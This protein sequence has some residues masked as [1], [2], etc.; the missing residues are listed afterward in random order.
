[1]KLQ[2]IIFHTI[3]ISIST[4]SIFGQ[5]VQKKQH[6]TLQSNDVNI[7]DEQNL[8]WSELDAYVGKY[9][10]DTGFFENDLVK[11]ELKKILDD[12]FN[13]Y[14]KFVET[15]GYGIIE[16]VDN[17][18][19]GD[20][21]MMHVGGYNS[22]FLIDTKKREMYLFWM[23]GAL[24]DKEYQI[25]G[26]RPIPETIKKIIEDDMNTGFGHVA[27]FYFKNDHLEI[28]VINPTGNDIQ[29]R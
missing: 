14:M 22:L 4:L 26:T 5:T 29:R 13:A 1:M 17:I 18:I 12:D 24:R 3:L 27:K 21:S 16:K 20:V 6:E 2:K 7:V 9:S 10:K 23:N 15:A 28:N 19:Y 8:K 25:Y 11:T